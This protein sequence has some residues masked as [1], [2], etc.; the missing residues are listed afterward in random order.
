MADLQLPPS[1]NDLRSH[2]LLGLV[3]RLKALDLTPILVYRIASLVDSAVLAMAW[4]WDVLNPLLAAGLTEA[5]QLSFPSWDAVTNIDTLLNIDL[6]DYQIVGGPG[7]GGFDPAIYRTLILLSTALHSTLGTPAALTNALSNLGFPGAVILE[8]QNSWGGT[9]W[10]A[11]EGWAVFRVL[12]DLL[13]AE[14]PPGV[15]IQQLVVAVCNYWKPARCWLDSVQFRVPVADLLLPAPSDSI[16]NIFLQLDRLK[17][18]PSD[19]IAAP[20][21]PL[22]DRKR[23]VPLHD[24]RYYHTGTTYGVNEP[25]VADDGVVVNGVAISA[26]G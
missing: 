18:A 14:V 2:A 25:H 20:G 22:S 21:W 11:N 9:S 12:I 15:D 7:P 5:E 17:P 1:I 26:N 10:P 23:I 13:T 4:Q 6:L 8:G 16:E 24:E 3:N 19:F